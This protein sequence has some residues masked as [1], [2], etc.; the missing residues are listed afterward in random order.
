MQSREGILGHNQFS[1]RLES[2]SML[3][4]VSFTG[5]FYR[6]PYSSLVL[7]ILTKTKIRETRKLEYIDEY[8]FVQRKN[9]G[10]K[11]DKNLSLTRF[12]FRPTNLD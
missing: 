11:P 12:K 4:T 10:R 5:G 9:E 7:K 3:F 6:G 2:C 1:K 8:H